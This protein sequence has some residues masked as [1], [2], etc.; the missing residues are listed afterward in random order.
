MA[1]GEAQ[2]F[3]CPGSG[4]IDFTPVFK[5]AD[6]QGI[7]HFMVE[8]DNAPDGLACLKSSARYLKTISF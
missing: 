8:C 1:S 6:S 7:E 4:I 5:E 2:D 3:E